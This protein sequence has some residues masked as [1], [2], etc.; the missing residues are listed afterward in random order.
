MRLKK[1]PSLC[2]RYFVDHA[3]YIQASHELATLQHSIEREQTPIVFVRR[4]CVCVC[5][6]SI[7]I[8]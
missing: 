6:R 3:R 1:N 8:F 7:Y 5:V 4:L 2:I